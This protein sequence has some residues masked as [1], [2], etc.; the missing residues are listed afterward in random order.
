VCRQL[1]S[2]LRAS[3][4]CL[5]WAYEFAYLL[6]HAESNA[7]VTAPAVTAPA[8][9]APAVT[10][11]QYIRPLYQ[12]LGV[13]LVRSSA[14]ASPLTVAPPVSSVALVSAGS[15]SA[16]VSSA[17]V[18]A[19]ALLAAKLA[20]WAYQ[21][22]GL[23][24]WTGA[25]LGAGRTAGVS[26]S[27]GVR[28]APACAIPAPDAPAWAATAGPPG[29]CSLC[30]CPRQHPTATPGGAVYCYAC[31]AAHLQREGPSCPVS[32]AYCT[33]ADLTKLY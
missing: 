5:R 31:I 1:H 14:L 9:T 2:A 16:P 4:R 24:G 8:V 17:F 15:S 28:L 29:E 6:R 11:F 21:Y 23:R 27:S 7:A 20:H 33:E 3:A 25:R 19:A 26:A 18:V 22:A 13:A 10:A 12:H 32:G 30:R